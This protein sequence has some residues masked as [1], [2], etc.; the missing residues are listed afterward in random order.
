MMTLAM[1]LDVTRQI[2]KRASSLLKR[3]SSLESITEGERERV[4]NQVLN[5]K[6]PSSVITSLTTLQPTYPTLKIRVMTLAPRFLPLKRRRSSIDHGK[7]DSRFCANRV[8]N[9]TVFLRMCLK[10]R[11]FPF[12]SRSTVARSVTPRIEVDA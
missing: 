1:T 6:A 7:I 4:S 11:Q 10:T 5:P 8:Q 3:A 2:L 12:Q 9:P